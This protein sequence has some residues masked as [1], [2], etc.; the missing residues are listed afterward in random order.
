M[1]PSTPRLRQ[2]CVDHDHSADITQSLVCENRNRRRNKH[3]QCTGIT[4]FMLLIWGNKNK[5]TEA[6]TRKSRLLSSTKGEKNRIES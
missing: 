5:T 6:K 1:A 4:R 3:V 2:P